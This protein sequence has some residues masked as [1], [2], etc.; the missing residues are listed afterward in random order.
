[1]FCRNALLF[2]KDAIRFRLGDCSLFGGDSFGFGAGRLLCGFRSLA[3]LT[4]LLFLGGGNDSLLA[5]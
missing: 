1:M 4:L 3:S 2:G 5:R